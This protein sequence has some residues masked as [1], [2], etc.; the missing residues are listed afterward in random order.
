MMNAPSQTP[1]REREIR[2]SSG[3]P[4]LPVNI[5]MLLGGPALFI[6]S[7]AAGVQSE[8][9][10]YWGLFATGILVLIGGI[11]MLC[12]FFTLQ[13]NEARVL[14]L[15]GEYRGTVRQSGFHW[16]NPFY[17]NGPSAGLQ[18]QAQAVAMAAAESGHK[19]TSGM[20]RKNPRNKI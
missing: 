20:T 11:L 17:S 5:L 19:G 13:P 2:V 14:V 18:A 15:F 4:L 16:G 6:Y 7:I 3:W 1:N 12:G 9:H 10:P 8:N